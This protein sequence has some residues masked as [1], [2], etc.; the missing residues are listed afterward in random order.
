VGRKQRINLKVERTKKK[1]KSVQSGFGLF[2]HRSHAS[3]RYEN[4]EHRIA[5]E[6]R[7]ERKKKKKKGRP[8]ERRRRF[9]NLFRPDANAKT[10][11]LVHLPLTKEREKR[12]SL[13]P[14]GEVQP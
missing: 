4:W 12:K 14:G 9:V 5:G 3:I 2:F 7:G 11:R 8:Q 1:K 10:R 13:D 6:G